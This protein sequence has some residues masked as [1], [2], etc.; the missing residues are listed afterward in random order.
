MINEISSWIMSI[1]GIICLSV[2]IELL[3]PDG[4]MNRYIKNIFS[5]IIVLVVILPL[6]KL[7]K[8]DFNYEN[9][10]YNQ[11]S[12]EVD[13]NYL[14]QLNLDR[15]NKLKYDIEEEILK[16]GYKNV[17]VY[18]NSSIFDNS[19][20]IKS[21]SVDLESLVITQNAEHNDISKIR[22]HI[23]QIIK[24]HIEIDEEEILYNV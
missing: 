10:F 20:L 9:I 24:K 14:Y 21:V 22:K 12:V 16:N 13:E 8:T 1:A 23:S 15:L 17:S 5:F 19:M 11:E 3:M 4:Q 2:L 18:L 6:P 7:L